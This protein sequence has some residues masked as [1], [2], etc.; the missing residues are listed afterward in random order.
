MQRAEHV[1]PFPMPLITTMDLVDTRGR[2][3]QAPGR[4]VS[5]V[6]SLTELICDLGRASSL[7][8]VTRYC[9]EPHHVT[10]A[11]AQ[12]GGTKDPDLGA[13]AA[14][15]PDLIVANQEENRREDIE[16]VLQLGLMVYLDHP[17]TVDDVRR[18][19]QAMGQIIEADSVARAI[20]LEIDCARRSI[21]SLSQAGRPRG[22]CPI[23]RRPY[24]VVGGAT[25]AGD[26]LRCGG[27]TNVFECHRG[28]GARYPVV[29]MEEIIAADPEVIVLP[30]EPYPF[31][32]RHRLEFRGQHGLGAMARQQ[33][34]L[35]D[36]KS[37][38]WYGKRTA[39]ALVA[40]ARLFANACDHRA[41]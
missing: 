32:D 24:M 37:I 27:G 6:P 34:H 2:L 9:E 25:Y 21:A 36:G 28:Q 33:I 7:V 12:V 19:V 41:R 40:L 31:A 11:L 16:R 26:L 1:D 17:R 3:G 30:D 39:A 22:L 4:I 38:S 29:T 23:W 14:L 20:V 5:L 13:I 8:G 18:S 10:R 35:I 15:R